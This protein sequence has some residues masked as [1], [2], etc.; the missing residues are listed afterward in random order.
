MVRALSLDIS[1]HL[2]FHLYYDSGGWEVRNCTLSQG[3]RRDILRVTAASSLIAGG[4]LTENVPLLCTLKN[5]TLQF[6]VQILCFKAL[7]WLS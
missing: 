1:Y 6:Q 4:H 3:V 2:D 5:V 7:C